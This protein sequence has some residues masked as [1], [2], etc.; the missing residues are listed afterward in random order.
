M[1]A[2]TSPQSPLKLSTPLWVKKRTHT[3]SEVMTETRRAVGGGQTA[4]S[5]NS[6]SG[7]QENQ[8][9]EAETKTAC[10]TATC[11]NGTMIIAAT[12]KA[13]YASRKFAQVRFLFSTFHNIPASLKLKNIFLGCV[14]EQNIDYNGNDIANQVLESMQACA[15]LCAS[16]PGGL[17]WTYLPTDKSCYVKS[18][19]SRRM[20]HALAV[21]GN[22]ECGSSAGKRTL[23]GTSAY[24]TSLALWQC[25]S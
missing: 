4:L 19:N 12:K 5:W 22:R 13:L 10:S 18:S 8:M 25:S 17:F 15:D 2:G 20:A 16:T 11:T 23:Q 21:S 9:M 3:G 24:M 14:T 6:L 7:L 1:K